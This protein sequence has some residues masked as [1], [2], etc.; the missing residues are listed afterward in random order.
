M[1]NN[2]PTPQ[3]IWTAIPGGLDGDQLNLSVSVFFSMC[4]ET[5]VPPWSAIPEDKYLKDVRPLLTDWPQQIRVCKLS[6]RAEFIDDSDALIES[7]DLGQPKTVDPGLW[8]EVMREDDES[9]LP[10][11]D[12]RDGKARFKANNAKCPD[13]YPYRSVED[14]LRKQQTRSLER[15]YLHCALQSVAPRE[16]QRVWGSMIGDAFGEFH[17]EQDVGSIWQELEWEAIDE[18][19]PNR[20]RDFST[21]PPPDDEE[22]RRRF[23]RKLGRLTGRE[24]VRLKG[25]VLNALQHTVEQ[26]DTVDEKNRFQKS[27]LDFETFHRRIPRPDPETPPTR[28]DTPI[29]SLIRRV[30]LMRNYVS[31]LER[32]GL[33]F[34]FPKINLTEPLKKTLEKAVGIR[35]V[36][37][38]GNSNDATGA[39]QSFSPTTQLAS[40]S[41]KPLF[42]ASRNPKWIT[43][44]DKNLSARPVASLLPMGDFALSTIEVDAAASRSRIAAKQRARVVGSTVIIDR[45]GRVQSFPETNGVFDGTWL[46]DRPIGRHLSSYLVSEDR[47]MIADL[48]RGIVRGN[49]RLVEDVEIRI[50]VGDADR[51]EHRSYRGRVVV[52][53]LP[54]GRVSNILYQ[55]TAVHAEDGWKSVEGQLT[56]EHVD[57]ELRRAI[58]LQSEGIAIVRKAAATLMEKAHERTRELTKQAQGDPSGTKVKLYADD[59]VLG[60][61]V[62]AGVRGRRKDGSTGDVQWRPLGARIEQF[63]GKPHTA[64]AVLRW[65]AQSADD[66]SD[67]EQVL[68]AQRLPANPPAIPPELVGEVL[69]MWNGNPIGLDEEAPSQHR[70]QPDEDVVDGASGFKVP[71]KLS[72]SDEKTQP[73]R[74]GHDYRMRCRVVD[75]AGN[76]MTPDEAD[77]AVDAGDAEWFKEKQFGRVAPIAPPT[78]LF[79]PRQTHLRS[80]AA[81]VRHL[82]SLEGSRDVRYLIPPRVSHQMAMLCGAFDQPRDIDEI[83]SFDAVRVEPDGSITEEPTRLDDRR[84]RGPEDAYY[85][86]DPAAEYAY[87]RLVDFQGFIVSKGC[88]SWY[89]GRSWPHARRVRLVLEG[90]SSDL[91]AHVEWRERR[92]ILFVRMPEGWTG[93]L[94]LSCGPGPGDGPRPTGFPAR[95]APSRLWSKE[96]FSCTNRVM[97]DTNEIADPSNV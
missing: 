13:S 95:L 25:K 15:E 85:Y 17:A 81:D 50:L 59:L 53:R 28:V 92:G 64:E 69:V 26:P 8:R 91:G 66:L 20:I 42:L 80:A 61:H 43:E 93:T 38:W 75:L 6:L 55:V 7:L 47:P 40:R 83:G 72:C 70:V 34:H 31:T 5:K 44:E 18:F 36:P 86:P 48:V 32:L 62:D 57:E 78:V 89:H 45:R 71:V 96:L 41:G 82:V 90:A 74:Y 87:Y 23:F 63:S 14:F 54:G 46:R 11:V 2:T 33:A 24:D 49:E 76:V 37:Q 68:N 65:G 19:V 10:L 4:S 1:H 51:P 3:S 29:W 67:Q 56:H 21:G 52:T 77:A 97:P 16:R 9:K 35:I 73:L 12:A 88:F 79:T 60:Y 94:E 39:L 22:Q 58:Y 84:A 30:A 27:F